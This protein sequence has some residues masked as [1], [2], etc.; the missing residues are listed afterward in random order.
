MSAIQRLRNVPT[1]FLVTRVIGGTSIP[2][3]TIE[4]ETNPYFGYPSAFQI[5]IVI[6]TQTHSSPNT[7]EGYVYNAYDIEVGDWFAQPSGKTYLIEEIISIIDNNAA[8]LKIKDENLYVLESDATQAANNFPD[9]EQAG[10]IFELDEDGN[11]ILAGITYQAAQ[12]P[13]LTYWIEDIKS[14]FE[15][16]SVDEEGIETDIDFDQNLD[17]EIFSEGTNGNGSSTGITIEYTP[18]ADSNVEV[19]INGIGVNLGNG[20]LT[21]D[22]YFSND[23]GITPKLI[24]NIEAGDILY[25]NGANAGYELDPLDDIDFEYEASNLDL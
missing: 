23:G 1:K 4:D 19:K 7:R 3:N 16:Y 13:G 24:K 17:A 8:I 9:E 6:D 12:F 5:E 20:I 10:A 15:Y 11:P 22:C 25:W 2:V 21:K 14:R 18:F